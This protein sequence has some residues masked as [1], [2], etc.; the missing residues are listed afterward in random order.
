MYPFFSPIM[1]E[2]KKRGYQVEF[3]A[4]DCFQVCG[5]A[6]LFQLKY[7]QIG[8]HYGKNKILKVV[9]TLIRAMQLLPTALKM[10]PILSVS[11]G[12]PGHN[13]SPQPC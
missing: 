2:L 3:T 12:F 9:G 4:R 11:H 7:K 1:N 10:K 8:R 13:L 5:L 6:D